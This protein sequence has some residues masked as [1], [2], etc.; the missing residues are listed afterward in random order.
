M[1]TFIAIRFDEAIKE[2]ITE[3]QDKLRDAAEKGHF[4]DRDNLHLTLIFLGE[5]SP[6]DIMK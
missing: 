2:K 3:V 6:N 1:R 5:V 4:T